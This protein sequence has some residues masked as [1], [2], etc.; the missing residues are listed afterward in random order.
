MRSIEKEHNSGST[1]ASLSEKWGVTPQV[2]SGVLEHRAAIR[3]LHLITQREEEAA[4][5]G[6][7][8]TEREA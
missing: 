7:N 6:F 8:W 3:R 5:V 2:I 4:A 1:L